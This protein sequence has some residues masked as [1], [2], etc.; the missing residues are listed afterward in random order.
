M[1]EYVTPLVFRSDLAIKLR[2]LDSIRADMTLTVEA[3]ETCHDTKDEKMREMLYR[4]ALINYRR[5]FTK[6]ARNS[7]PLNELMKG[8]S[9]DAQ[10]YHQHLKDMADKFAAH[11]VNAYETA[12][13]CVVLNKEGKV[14]LV[15]VQHAKLFRPDK[16]E[17]K[18]FSRFASLLIE[19]IVA[20]LEETS[21]ATFLE[22]CSLSKAE[23]DRLEE[24]K[25]TAPGP[26]AAGK[27]RR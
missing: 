25:Y 12:E 15:Y 10:Q 24:W 20:E 8:L 6:G 21:K 22:A 1:D 13:T 3:L 2:D 23:L 7:Q 27:R 11:S 9:E 16:A 18:Q 14:D 26:G 17:M 5:C 19:Q 4:F